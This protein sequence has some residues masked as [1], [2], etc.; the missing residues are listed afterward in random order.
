MVINDNVF[1]LDPSCFTSLK[2]WKETL[3]V[4][5]EL[6]NIHSSVIVYI[7]SELYDTIMLPPKEKF[8]RLPITLKKWLSPLQYSNMIMLN[9]RD[10]DEYVYTTRKF[11]QEYDHRKAGSSVGDIRKIGNESI[12][13]DDVITA[14][15]MTAGTILFEMMALSSSQIQAKIISFGKRTSSLISRLGTPI[16]S[17]RSALK[18]RIKDNKNIRGVLGFM[19]FAINTDSVHQFM[20][21]YQI[22]N[23]PLALH[24][25]GTAGLLFIADGFGV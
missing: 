11:I 8:E 4:L 21:N 18:H 17:A 9:E 10:K 14:F 24:D 12:Y 2:R 16:M 23:L 15:G 22:L 25:V 3:E 13:L 6:R 20:Q 7:S 1:C 5:D 19:I